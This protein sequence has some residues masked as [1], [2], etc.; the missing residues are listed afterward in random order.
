MFFCYITTCWT[1]V[2]SKE[3]TIGVVARAI[4]IQESW[5]YKNDDITL[6]INIEAKEGGLVGHGIITVGS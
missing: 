1:F 4:S 3:W 2:S 6:I 5:D